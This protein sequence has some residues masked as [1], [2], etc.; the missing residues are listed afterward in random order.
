MER[1]KKFSARLVA[2]EVV[3]C[4]RMCEIMN[5]RDKVRVNYD[6]VARIVICG[7]L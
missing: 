6:V 4:N 5:V 2:S 3:E 1:D 7:V